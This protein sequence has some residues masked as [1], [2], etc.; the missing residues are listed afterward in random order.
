MDAATTAEVHRVQRIIRLLL[1]GG[2]AVAVVSM[3][4]GLTLKIASGSRRSAAVELFSLGDAGSPADLLM[5]LGVL[6]L[7]L[8]P[9]FRVL[10]LVVLWAREH[11]WRFVGVAVAVIVTLGVAVI[12]GHG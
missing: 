4:L 8:T 6:A 7:A 9:A 11:D 5:A 3:A 2:L 1:R 10:A 12:V